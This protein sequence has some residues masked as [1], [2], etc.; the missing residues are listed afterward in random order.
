MAAIFAVQGFLD[1]QIVVT[2]SARL[3]YRD[4]SNLAFRARHVGDYF[5]AEDFEAE[6]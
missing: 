2:A 6:G 1:G 5:V 4:L 3:L